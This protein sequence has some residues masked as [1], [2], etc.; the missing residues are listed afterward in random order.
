MEARRAIVGGDHDIAIGG[1]LLLQE[2][3]IRPVAKDGGDAA[4]ACLLILRMDLA[5]QLQKGRR[6]DPS[7]K[8]KDLSSRKGGKVIPVSEDPQNIQ[9][10]PQLTLRELLRPLSHDAEHEAQLPLLL[11][12]AADADGPGQNSCTVLRIDADELPGAHLLRGLPLPVLQRQTVHP[13]CKRLTC[14]DSQRPLCL[15]TA[16][17]A[18]PYPWVHILNRYLQ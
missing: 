16:H 10:L 18:P 6:A 9:R 3:V 17:A 1:K 15:L 13:C 14:G 2:Q 12:P 5:R 7:A 4:R 11:V 8:K